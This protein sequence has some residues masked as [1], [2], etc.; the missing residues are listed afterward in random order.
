M[1]N[2]SSNWNWLAM[3]PPSWPAYTSLVHPKKKTFKFKKS[4]KKRTREEKGPRK[5]E[6]GYKE[7]GTHKETQVHDWPVSSHWMYQTWCS[8]PMGWIC[9]HTPRRHS[10]SWDSKIAI[11]KVPK[12][13]DKFHVLVELMERVTSKG[14]LFLEKGPGGKWYKVVNLRIKAN[15]IFWDSFMNIEREQSPTA[16]QTMFE[17]GPTVSPSPV[18]VGGWNINPIGMASKEW[19]NENTDD[20]LNNN[21]DF[22]KGLTFKEEPSNHQENQLHPRRQSICLVP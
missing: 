4:C 16:Y 5:E 21:S 8:L 2:S 17:Q 22:F 14:H 7:E 18:T 3:S 19:K 11:A 6:D 12:M 1:T 20:R 9:Q 13:L 10:C 15:Q